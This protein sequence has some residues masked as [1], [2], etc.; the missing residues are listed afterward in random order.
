L[1]ETNREIAQRLG[2]KPNT[3]KSHMGWVYLVLGLHGVH[4]RRELAERMREEGPF[5]REGTD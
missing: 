4:N 2:I 5:R 3:V 1:G